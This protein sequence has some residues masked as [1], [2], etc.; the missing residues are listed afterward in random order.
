MYVYNLMFICSVKPLFNLILNNLLFMYVCIWSVLMHT[1][2]CMYVHIYIYLGY[3][4][5]RDFIHLDI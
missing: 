2:M 5:H 4:Q 3:I 1:C